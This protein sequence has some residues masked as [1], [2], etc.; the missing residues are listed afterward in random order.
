[1]ITSDQQMLDM[2]TSEI[3]KLL[4]RFAD[5][6]RLSDLDALSD[7]LTDDFKLVGPLGFVVPKQ[8]WLEQFQSGALRIES[9]AWD[10]LEIRTHAYANIAIAIGRLTQAATYTQNR[11]DGQFRVTAIAIGHGTTWH[12][13]G[14]HY[15]P[16]AAPSRPRSADAPDERPNTHEKEGR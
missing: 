14:L 3:S 6:Q 1:M 11:S 2:T 16:I 10:E 4:E 8:Q 9:L 12:L 5:A 15:S 7:L 13:A